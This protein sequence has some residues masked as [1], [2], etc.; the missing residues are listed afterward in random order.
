MTE[1]KKEGV[2]EKTIS[3]A[4]EAQAVT[5]LKIAGLRKGKNLSTLAREAFALWWEKENFASQ[6]GP[7][8]SQAE[9]SSQE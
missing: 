7:L 1:T 6:E 4:L 3:I 5:R 9:E 2:V 8:F